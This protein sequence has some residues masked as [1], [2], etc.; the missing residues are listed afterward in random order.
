MRRPTITRIA[1]PLLLGA[2]VLFGNWPVST[3]Q[4]QGHKTQARTCS[5]QSLKGT[6][7]VLINGTI[8]DVGP[9][10]SVG[11][12]TFDGNGSITGYEQASLN[13]S[14]G[15]FTFAGTYGVDTDCTGSITATFNPGDFEGHFFFVILEKSK[16]VMVVQKD[17]GTIITWTLKRQ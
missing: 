4:A 3:A 5:L 11:V 8:A 1:T 6:Y 7:G 2:V 16:E 12:A 10:T 15:L 9:F 17:Q 13:G 14:P